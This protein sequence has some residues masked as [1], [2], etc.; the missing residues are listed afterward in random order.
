MFSTNQKQYVPQWLIKSLSPNGIPTAGSKNAAHLVA[1]TVSGLGLGSTI[2]LLL[3]SAMYAS[4]TNILNKAKASPAQD[5][6]KIYKRP[7]RPALSSKSQH[8]KVQRKQRRAMQKQASAYDAAAVAIPTS[9]IL[10]AFLASL[11]VSDKMYDNIQKKQLQKQQLKLKRQINDKMLQ[12]VYNNRGIQK[13]AE[14]QD[15]GRGPIQTFFSRVGSAAGLAALTLLVV[16]GAAGYA[17]ANDKN[18]SLLDYKARKQG[19]QAYAKARQAQDSTYQLAMDKQL[20]DQLDSKLTGQKPVIDG[21][22]AYKTLQ[23]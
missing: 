4:S 11:N 5:L 7:Y 22:T 18:Q 23:V 10:L 14:A 1:K 12:R 13:Q 17:Y 8:N 3:R 2:A 21:S 16:S 20:V 6:D 9:A 15:S 19:L